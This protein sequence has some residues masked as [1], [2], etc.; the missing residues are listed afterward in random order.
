[1]K[2][3]VIRQGDYLLKLAHLHGFDADAV[4]SDPKN[5]ELK[6]LRED[7]E[8]LRP[9]DVVFVP[10]EPKK[11][12]RL[13]PKTTNT[14]VARVPFVKVSVV[15]SQDGQALKNER[16]VVDGL[17]D[18]T[19]R[20]TDGEGRV[21]VDVPVHVREIVVRLVE[22]GATMKLAVGELDPVETPSG[23]RMRLTSLG[24]YGAKLAGA[25][26]WVAHDPDALSAAI[27]RFQSASALTVTGALDDATREALVKAHGS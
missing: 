18:D 26:G 19:E 15:L 11:K 22:L 7:P 24:H 17:G 5:A 9:G 23:A 16:Y 3:Y 27:R 4:W 2:P 12:L 13:E 14:F 6:A 20:V 1:M 21:E 25:D 8:M 10:D